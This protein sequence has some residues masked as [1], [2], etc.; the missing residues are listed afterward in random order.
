MISRTVRHR[1]TGTGLAFLLL[2]A[3]ALTVAGCFN[4]FRPDELSGGISKPPPRPDTPGNTLRLLEWAY[5]KRAI[6]E[7]SELFTADFR[8][9]FGALDPLG[10]A[11]QD[12]TPWGREDELASAIKLFE[13]SASI[14]LALD[15]S[16]TLRRD[17][18]PGKDPGWHKAIRTT[19]QLTV[20]DMDGVRRDVG[21][22]SLFFLVR[23]DSALIPQELKDKGFGPDPGRWYIDRW[24]DE[25]PVEPGGITAGGA[26]D[27]RARLAGSSRTMPDWVT[28]GY[29]KARWR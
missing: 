24:E 26:A 16:F 15:P 23:G 9:V 14:S 2:V 12:Q 8:F 7:Y 13:N 6:A 3:S 11:Y 25:S 22:T 21:G 27:L 29:I 4:P 19:Q 10:N 17:P 18:R 5:N 1:L 28:W 20:V